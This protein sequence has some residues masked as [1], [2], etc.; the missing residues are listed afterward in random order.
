MFFNFL[1]NKI[2]AQTSN[3]AKFNWIMGPRF[4]EANN[5]YSMQTHSYD[6]R[7]LN[8]TDGWVV[9][10]DATE[11]K[12]PF[13]NPVYTWLIEG[14]GN[15]SGYKKTYSANVPNYAQIKF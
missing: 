9:K 6:K 12:Q 8:E 1:N 13:S 4:E 15:L 7:I 14:L 3:Y 11:S 10:L 5:Y 2:T